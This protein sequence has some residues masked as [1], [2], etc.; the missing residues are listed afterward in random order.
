MSR[1]RLLM[2]IV[3]AAGFAGCAV[4]DTCDDFPVPCVGPNCGQPLNSGEVGGYS[5]LAPART[6]DP[7]ADAP[8][9]PAYVNPAD[10][11]NA[12]PAPVPTP[13]P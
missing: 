2:L 4:C 6:V 13:N 12:M 1:I 8:T 7:T 3:A 5:P 9:S 10:A 11:P